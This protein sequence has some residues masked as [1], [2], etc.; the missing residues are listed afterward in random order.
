M[1]DIEKAE[2]FAD[3][4]NFIKKERTLTELC[5]KYEMSD[6]EMMGIIG[7][8]KQEGMPIM[9]KKDKKE[10]TV[11]INPN[12]NQTNDSI[13]QL[14]C[15]GS[16]TRFGVVSDTILGSKYQQLTILNN[17][18]KA[19]DNE[20]VEFVLHCGDISAGVYSNRSPYADTIFKHGIDEQA[21]Y[22][23]EMYPNV[24]IP[25]YFITGEKDA[26]HKKADKS[27]RDI[28][29]LISDNRDDMIYLGQH[30]SMLQMKN[31]K[32]ALKHPTGKVAYTLSYKAQQDAAAMRSE[33]KPDIVFYGH[34]LSALQMD[35]RT[36]LYTVPGLSAT[37]PWMMDGAIQNSV[38]A[39]IIDLEFDQKGRI[40][41][42]FPTLLPY[43]ETDANDYNHAKKLLLL[44]EDK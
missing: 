17:V 22:I 32:L 37:T 40:A 33:E 43:Y 2:L 9:A 35:Y 16:S 39:W 29:K 1:D 8:L 34:W 3:I 41:E 25:T 12:L 27:H 11:V 23:S 36:K 31:A 14:E 20:N 18:Y 24:G 44:K 5:E 13:H 19:F 21:D 10:V 15:E 7:Q 30:R 4:R 28:G 38:G 42:T 26:A 6:Y